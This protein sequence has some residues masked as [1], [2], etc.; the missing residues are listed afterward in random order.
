M[1]EIPIVWLVTALAS[2]A[3]VVIAR[4]ARLTDPSRLFLAFGVAGIGVLGLLLG[5]RLSFER[6]WAG[7]L[8]PLVGLTTAPALYLGLDAL[9]RDGP[10]PWRSVLVWHW[11]PISLLGLGI[12]TTG[13]WLADFAIP[14][15]TLVYIGLLSRLALRPLEAF[16]HVAPRDQPVVKAL[17]LGVIAL[18]SFFLLADVVIFAALATGGPD[19]VPGLVGN[20]A[21]ALTVLVFLAALLGGPA[22]LSRRDGREAPVARAAEVTE[23]DRALLARFDA[24]MRDTKLFTDSGLTLARAARRLGVPARRVSEAINR[25]AGTNVSRHINGFR[26]A[27]AQD[28]LRTT[29]LPVTEVMLEAGFLSKSTFNTEFRRITGQT[30]STFRATLA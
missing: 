15:V 11:V 7:F 9:T 23:E 3:V 16:V 1:T 4:A 18:F 22:L 6:D 26:V 30:P 10:Y 20:A 29:D 27:H 5:L 12:L 14:L 13:F 28:L 2:I 24:L 8:Q 25:V 19:A 21:M 17:V